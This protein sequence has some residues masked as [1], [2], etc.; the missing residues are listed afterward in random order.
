MNRR[1][2]GLSMVEVLVAFAILAVAVLALL[3][4]LPAAARQQRSSVGASQALY[5]AEEKMDILLKANQKIST[6]YETDNPYG[7]ATGSRRWWGTPV[8]GNSGVQ[9][10]NVEVTWVDRGQ[11]TDQQPHIR[12]ITLRS[13]VAP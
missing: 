7:N 8:A 12:T 13:M 1:A 6:A 2:R 9:I 4:A 5:Y 3:G 10:I 11:N